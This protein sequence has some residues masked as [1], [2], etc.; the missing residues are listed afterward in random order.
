[1]PYPTVKGKRP[2]FAGLALAIAAFFLAEMQ[3]VDPGQ[4]R[5]P[6]TDGTHTPGNHHHGSSNP[7]G[8][9]SHM[10]GLTTPTAGGHGGMGGD[11]AAGVPGG[12]VLAT[13]DRAGTTQGV[14]VAQPVG[15]T[16]G[17]EPSMMV[18]S[19][20]PMGAASASGEHPARP[21]A[22]ASFSGISSTRQEAADED[23]VPRLMGTGDLFQHANSGA[24]QRGG[25]KGAPWESVPNVVPDEVLGLH[26]TQAKASPAAIGAH[27]D[28]WHKT[29]PPQSAAGAD[30]DVAAAAS[31]HGSSS[32][33]SPPE[34]TL[35]TALLASGQPQP[36]AW[37]LPAGVEFSLL[38]A[39]GAGHARATTTPAE[40][41]AAS[42]RPAAST[43]EGSNTRTMENAGRANARWPLRPLQRGHPS[44]IVV[45]SG[46]SLLGGGLGDAIDAFPDIIRF[47]W[48]RTRGFERDVGQRT[49]IVFA[50]SIKMPFQG[51]S[52]LHMPAE[53]DAHEGATIKEVY[54]IYDAGA[55]PRTAK[56]I[57][58]WYKDVRWGRGGAAKVRVGPLESTKILFSRYHLQERFAST[59]LQAL[60]FA[61][62]RFGRAAYVGFDFHTGVHGHYYEE[63]FKKDTCHNMSDEARVLKQL[64]AE[65][66]LIS[67]GCLLRDAARKKQLCKPMHIKHI[68]HNPNCK[69]VGQ[70]NVAKES[71]A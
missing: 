38:P 48:F 54:A 53:W 69:I 71:M 59:G 37:D 33:P 24:G 60:M 35:V 30:D 58:D 4:R 22:L 28:S 7:A 52:Q 56:K 3:L 51:P 17:Q 67:L 55:K 36:S 25:P 20:M 45:G 49:T 47:V 19:S 9:R 70:F 31:S 43:R 41:H 14:G 64:E 66:K 16:R 39:Q 23:P 8:T 63:K 32:V 11:S 65:G 42:P 68:P 15:T 40:L 1:M 12:N 27:V 61:V 29:M 10:A 5:A 46:L 34:P 2:V 44:V 21:A 62:Q 18:S 50:P 13:W 26:G 57:Q 6:G